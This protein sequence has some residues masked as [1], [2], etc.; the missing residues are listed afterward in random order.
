MG[1]K[2]RKRKSAPPQHNRRASDK[3]QV[4]TPAP[5]LPGL[6]QQ[7]G[8]APTNGNGQPAQVK[9]DRDVDV[10]RRMPG[11]EMWQGEPIQGRVP[12]EQID[13]LLTGNG[14]IPN[15]HLIREIRRV[16][17]E[18]VKDGSLVTGLQAAI[19]MAQAK[20]QIDRTLARMQNPVL[21]RPADESGFA[22]GLTEEYKNP[23]DPEALNARKRAHFAAEKAAAVGGR[24]NGPAVKQAPSL[25]V[26][27]F[28]DLLD[29]ELA[30][31]DELIAALEHR[32]SFLVYNGPA[33]GTDVDQKQ[34]AAVRPMPSNEL[35]GRID[36]RV[37]RAA[38]IR[39]RLEQL[40]E[41]LRV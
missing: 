4:K 41:S 9:V 10:N 31:T 2:N 8:A 38:S 33:G 24:G 40:H 32:L 27:D 21:R 6:A 25:R 19:E 34:T 13:D 11:S 12:K 26:E 23:V 39:N 5:G 16:L 29:T 17:F 15:R 14:P 18:S 37:H 3:A 35:E 28:F 36:H 30:R 20:E 1:S 22:A 7:Q